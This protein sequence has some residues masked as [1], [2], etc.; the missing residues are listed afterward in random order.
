MN[1]QQYVVEIFQDTFAQMKDTP[2]ILYG[3]G[4]NTEAILHQTKG[5]QFIG[6]MDSQN[7]GKKFWGYEV[8]PEEMVLRLK[9]LIVIIARESV[10]PIIYKRIAHL[11]ENHGIQIYNFRGELLG[12]EPW[13]YQNQALPYWNVKEKSLRETI[14]EHDCISFDIFD[15]LLM[16]RVLEPKN[17]FEI[18]ERLLTFKGYPNNHFKKRRICAEHSL[19]N[20]PNIHRIYEKIGQLYH[21][22][23]DDLALWKQ[24]EMEVERKLLVPRTKMVD[25]F[26]DCI[27]SGKRVYLISDMY[28]SKSELQELLCAH[29]IVGYLDLLVSC[30]YGK[31]K[32]DGGLYGI[33]RKLAGGGC[34]LHIGDNRRSDGEKAKEYGIDTFLIYSAY[35]M[36]MASSMQTTL[37]HVDSLEQSCILANLIWRYCEDPFAL[38]ESKGRVRID[39]GRLLGY[40]FLGPLY[41]EFI[42]WLREM[43]QE[44]HVEQL[45]LPARDGY[46]IERMLKQEMVED[47]EVIYFKASRRA[48]SVA[49]IYSK[50]DILKRIERVFHGTFGALLK[51]RFGVDAKQE[52][53]KRNDFVTW[54][55]IDEVQAYVMM[56]VDEILSQAEK[57]HRSYLDY[58]KKKGMLN[59]RKKALFDFIAGG[60]VQHFLSELLGENL[61]GFYFASM[62]LPNDWYELGK[63]ILAAYGNLCSYGTENQVGKY[64]LMLETVM[65]DGDPTLVCVNEDGDFC[66]EDTSVDNSAN[67]FQI[68][69]GILDFQ[70][71]IGYIKALLPDWKK[72]LKFADEN[73]GLLFSDCCQVADCVKNMFVNDDTFDGIDSYKVWDSGR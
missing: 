50:D 28:F 56:Y 29:N 42:H 33:Y 40:L 34:F 19:R 16:R 51:Q 30:D 18:V 62:N 7:I 65:T 43:V 64:Y 58:L 6:L 73:F 39:T 32:E 25:V 44:H 71:D 4:K 3:L 20:Y 23:S 15:T 12:Q 69:N 59:S 9:P 54:E 72:E 46:L 14:D 11:K 60:T 21:I 66:Y 37:S 5:F 26:H 68:Q 41:A 52:D 49:S 27:T 63:E 1:E 47:C 13:K 57:E 61:I 31:G 36:W 67:M 17:I 55:K 10:V 48:V 22:S 38:A 53:N 8:L 70:R 45:L 24:T 35:E 2:I